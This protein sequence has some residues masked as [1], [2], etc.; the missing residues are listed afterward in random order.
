MN[1]NFYPLAVSRVV[2]ETKDTVSLVLDVSEDLK[3]IF[4]YKQGQYLTLRFNINGQQVRRAYSMSSS[5]L[6]AQLKVS[7][8][9]VDKGLVSNYIAASVKAGD[10]IQVMPPQGRFYTE[11]N[12]EHRKT[13]Y[14]FGA[15]SGIT[16][17]MSILKTVLEEEPQSAV[18]LLYGNRDEDSIIFKDEIDMLQKKYGEQFVCVHTL[19]QPKVQKPKGLG[20]FFKKGTTTWQGK[21]GRIDAP[22][23][24]AFFEE[25]P[26]IYKDAEYFICG[27]DQMM[28]TVEA[29]LKGLDI[30]PNKIHMER[31]SSSVP[32]LKAT[33]TSDDAASADGGDNV[34]TVIIH[35]D[36]KTHT[37]QLRKKESVLDA[38][39]RMKIDVPYSCTSG[40]CSTCMGKTLKGS[41]EME[42]C[43][44]LDD[45]EVEE[46]YVL[47]CQTRPTSAGVEITFD[48]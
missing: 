14:L 3:E 29:S 26:T 35:L 45:D 2:Q 42:V 20:G 48:V 33:D 32:S 40:A 39:I 15:G 43:F 46:G 5:P 21:V 31:F 4:T 10:V 27:P 6:E 36:G 34:N 12:P 13:Y 47:T 18:R 16:P 19:S 25:Y 8:K 23:I 30:A 24:K 44:A 17:L 9:R 41:T 11:L 7:V 1:R 37:L 28:D 38:A 22:K